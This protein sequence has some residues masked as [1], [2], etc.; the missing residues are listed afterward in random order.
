MLSFADE[1][2]KF[3]S[4]LNSEIKNNFLKTA[5]PQHFSPPKIHSPPNPPARNQLCIFPVKEKQ[6]I[7]AYSNI[8]TENDNHYHL[9]LGGISSGSTMQSFYATS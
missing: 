9:S 7:Y 4:L 3:M 6:K 8:D 1:R 5:I 2:K